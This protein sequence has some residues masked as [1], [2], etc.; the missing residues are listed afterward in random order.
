M[1]GILPLFS[2]RGGVSGFRLSSPPLSPDSSNNQDI[3]RG[4]RSAIDTNFGEPNSPRIC[5]QHVWLS[6][7]NRV[8]TPSFMVLSWGLVYI[9]VRCFG[10]RQ[11]LELCS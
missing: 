2:L 7:L 1:N 3:K 11:S 6:Q 5:S 4:L 10:V 9:Y 8:R